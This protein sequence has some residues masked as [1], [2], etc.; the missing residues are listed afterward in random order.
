MAKN[1]PA[2]IGHVLG[3]FL[4]ALYLTIFNFNANYAYQ[5]ISAVIVTLISL[6]LITY[7]DKK[8]IKIVWYF[9]VFL[10]GVALVSSIL[11]LM[12]PLNVWRDIFISAIVAASVHSLA[13]VIF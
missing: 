13:K 8:N 12:V 6:F 5:I 9:F 1:N 4:V 11:Y 7:F 2:L 3:F 10:I